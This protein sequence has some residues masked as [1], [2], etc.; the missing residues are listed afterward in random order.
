MN[1]PMMVHVYVYGMKVTT[2]CGEFQFQCD[3]KSCIMY[4]SVCNGKVDCKSG[5]YESGEDESHCGCNATQ[6]LS[7]VTYIACLELPYEIQKSCH[8][9]EFVCPGEKC[10]PYTSVCDGFQDCSQNADEICELNDSSVTTVTKMEEMYTCLSGDQIPSK[11]VNDLIPDCYNSDDEALYL[12]KTK[13]RLVYDQTCQSQ[14]ML[15]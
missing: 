13:H 2:D 9:F 8:P 7:E 5:G 12:N 3:D 10:I 6:H 1:C 4:T 11:Y 15:Q 14:V